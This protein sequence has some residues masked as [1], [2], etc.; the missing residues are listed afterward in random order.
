MILFDYLLH[1]YGKYVA[2][3]IGGEIPGVCRELEMDQPVNTLEM[4]QP[5]R[6]I[7]GCE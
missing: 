5:I 4:D 6:E 2:P 1:W 7:V 3:V